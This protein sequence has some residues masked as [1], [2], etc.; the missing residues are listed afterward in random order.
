FSC[1]GATGIDLFLGQT[2]DRVIGKFYLLCDLD[3]FTD[4]RFDDAAKHVERLCRSVTDADKAGRFVRY[5]MP[6]ERCDFFLRV[7]AGLGKARD[8]GRAALVVRI[9][10][11]V[12]QRDNPKHVVL[13]LRRTT[14]L[15]RASSVVNNDDRNLAPSQIEQPIVYEFPA[16]GLIFFHPAGKR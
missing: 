6:L 9:L 4:A 2:L 7:P 11:R 10:L 5:Q 8:E 12:V 15:A 14:H 13:A 16:I 3:W 1:S